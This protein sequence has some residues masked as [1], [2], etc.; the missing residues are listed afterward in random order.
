MDEDDLSDLPPVPEELHSLEFDGPFTRCTQ[1]KRS[2]GGEED[3]EPYQLQKVMKFGEPIIEFALCNCCHGELCESFSKLTTERLE[4]YFEAHA[5]PD[6]AHGIDACLF[7]VMPRRE[8]EEYNLAGHCLF[9]RLIFGSC[10]CV[11]CLMKIQPLFSKQ[12]R[13][14][15][16]RFRERNF[17]GVPADSKPLFV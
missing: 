13:D 12:T 1:C 5:K 4:A 11:T 10:I 3:A 2:I 7:C 8:L 6:L 15:R 16:D 14:V 17:P 9:N